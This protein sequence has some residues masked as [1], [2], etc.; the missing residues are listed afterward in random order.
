VLAE[1]DPDAEFPEGVV[2]VPRGK[3]GGRRKV[4]LPEG[5]LDDLEGATPP[6]ADAE[7]AGSEISGG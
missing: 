5:Y 3:T 6:S 1:G 4:A 7:T 2:R